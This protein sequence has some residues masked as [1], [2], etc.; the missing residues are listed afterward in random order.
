MKV[1]SSALKLLAEWISF[2]W[3]A[4]PTKLRPTMLELLVGAMVSRSGHIT[5][6][7]LAIKTRR[8]WNTYFKS[9]QEG[10]FHW[11][12]LARRWLQLLIQLVGIES[13]NLAVDDFLT[14]RS[15]KKAPASALHHDHA[16]RTNRPRFVWGQL[17]VG[18]AAII[19]VNGRYG[20]FPLLLHLVRT[21]GNY[22][23]LRSARLLMNI[24]L[25][26]FP[27]LLSVRLLLDAWYMKASLVMSL[28]NKG[29]TVIGQVRRDTVLC[30]L[31]V[32]KKGPGRPAKYGKRITLPRLQQENEPSEITFFA[33]GKNLRF[34]YYYGQAKV[35]FLKGLLARFVWCR[36]QKDTAQW[37]N[38]HLLL[39]TD[40]ELN[41]A[42]VI[43]L[44]TLRWWVEPMFNELK[45]LFGMKS[46][47]QQS[48]QVLARW[49]MILSL[50]YSLPKLLA[51]WLGPEQGSRFFS[52]PWRR[53]KPIT[54]GWIATG[55][56]YYFRHF[57]VRHLWDRKRQ[58]MTFPQD[59]PG[60][61]FQKTA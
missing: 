31:P 59:D 4:F 1:A 60:N 55:L 30:D 53:N 42:T 29:M 58:K 5:D 54:A 18:L 10:R 3:V 51:L 8:F 45:N 57:P 11:M 37:T 35:R 17:R 38:W 50:A 52:I 47:W 56:S 20:A 28:I 19:S 6:A 14:F 33:Y 13:I 16:H 39:C 48:K 22:S 40:P 49:T 34:Q 44:F 61:S 2:L 15:S 24:V 25:R 36:F 26:W 21:S 9:I 32:R 43:R 23:K 27:D 12:K 46:A 41:P 7:F